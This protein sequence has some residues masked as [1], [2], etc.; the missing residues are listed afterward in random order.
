MVPLR[1][2]LALLFFSLRRS[3]P[4]AR[5]AV[6]QVTHRIHYHVWLGAPSGKNSSW[7]RE[8]R[9][10]EE[11]FDNIYLIRFNDNSECVEIREWYRQK[12][13]AE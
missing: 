1:N 8:D 12:P 6:P 13:K 11:E 3:H 7:R 9:H 10:A 5:F 2:S 4:G